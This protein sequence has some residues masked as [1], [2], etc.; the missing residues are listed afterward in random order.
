MPMSSARWRRSVLA[1]RRCCATGSRASA[2][3]SWSAQMDDRPRRGW[4][5]CQRCAEGCHHCRRLTPVRRQTRGGLHKTLQPIVEGKPGGQADDLH[6]R[7]ADA[8][9]H[10]RGERRPDGRGIAQH[11]VVRVGRC[12]GEQSQSNVGKTGSG[13]NPHLFGGGTSSRV[14]AAS[15]RVRLFIKGSGTVAGE[16]S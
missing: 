10:Q 5:G 8:S 1:L 11:V 14:S 6:V 2:Q 7:H 16:E 15:D 3:D 4:R 13:R 12:G 9:F